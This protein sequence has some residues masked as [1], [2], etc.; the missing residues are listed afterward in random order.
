MA[1]MS[2]SAASF[3]AGVGPYGLVADTGR[4]RDGARQP[5]SKRGDPTLIGLSEAEIDGLA[6]N[7]IVALPDEPF[8][9][10]TPEFLRAV[11]VIY[12]NDHLLEA[13]APLIRQRFIDRLK[14]SSGWRRLVGT[15]SGSIETHLGPAIG[16]IFFND[17]AL[18]QTSTYL[19]AKAIERIGPFLPQLIELLTS[20]PSYFAAF[21]TM[22]LLEASPHPLLL[23]LLV[24]GGK[25]WIGSYAD[26]TA[27]WVG[28]GIG[29]RFCTVVDRLRQTAP[30]A[31]AADKPERQDIDMILA[32][33]VRLGVP[34]ARQLETALANR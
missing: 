19:T 3:L 22:D 29:R 32:A 17:Y 25:A 2:R 7:R 13:E 4:R 16:T 8:F 5:W 20:G 24:A 9:N 31:L 33:L 6:L 21:V 12:F 15:R 28:Y 11:D 1:W 23:P 30:E 18:R 14:T 27:L 10:V 34:E 26:D